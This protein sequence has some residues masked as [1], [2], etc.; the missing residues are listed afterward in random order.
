M[1]TTK[2]SSK[3]QVILPKSVRDANHWRAGMEFVVV[4]TPDG[5]LLRPRKPFSPTRLQDV[6]GCTKYQ[7]PAKTVAEMNQAISAAAKDRRASGRY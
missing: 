7:G 1:E 4:N 5:V 3:G 2:L 6:I